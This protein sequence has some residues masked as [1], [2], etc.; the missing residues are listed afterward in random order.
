MTATAASPEQDHAKIISNTVAW[1]ERAVIGLNLCPFAKA[2]H[3]NGRIHYEVSAAQD[4]EHLMLDLGQSMERLLSTDPNTMETLLLIHPLAFNDFL[5]Y[6]DFVMD[7]EDLLARL[8]LDGVLQIASFHPHYQF[9]ETSPEAI[10]NYT[11]RSPYPML[12]LLREDSVERAVEAFP[13]AET[14]YERNIETMKKLGLKRWHAL[15]PEQA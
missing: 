8:N 12:H 6:N 5:D 4:A 15:F 13:D 10:E 1:V 9:A 2:E 14:I 3:V 11:N 7:A